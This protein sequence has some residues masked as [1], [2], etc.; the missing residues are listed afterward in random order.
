MALRLLWF[1]AVKAYKR[2]E[3]NKRGF[4]DNKWRKNRKERR[5]CNMRGIQRN[6]N[7]KKMH[8]ENNPRPQNR[9]PKAGVVFAAHRYGSAWRLMSFYASCD[10]QFSNQAPVAEETV[11][12][13][14]LAPTTIY[15]HHHLQKCH[16][17]TSFPWNISLCNTAI[18]T[19]HG[20]PSIPPSYLFTT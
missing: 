11:L 17:A 10:S 7:R 18:I 9:P 3:K 19:L 16:L 15:H 5:D 2:R 1:L 12:P 6:I 13:P 4:D 8:T 14:L 20:A